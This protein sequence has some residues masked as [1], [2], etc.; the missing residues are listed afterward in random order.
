MFKY[1]VFLSAIVAVIYAVQEQQ[2]ARRPKFL[3]VVS[4]V[5]FP[6]SPCNGFNSTTGTCLSKLSCSIFGGNNSGISCAGGYGVCCNFFLSCG[7]VI[8][9]NNSYFVNPGYPDDYVNEGRCSLNVEKI[10]SNIEQIRLN[11][12]EFSINGVTNRACEQDVFQ[13]TGYNVNSLVPIFCGRNAGQ[14][15]Y[16][17]V[18]SVRGPL[19]LSM[20]TTSIGNRRWRIRVIQLERNNPS[21]TPRGCLQFFTGPSGN[22]RSFNYDAGVVSGQSNYLSNLN[23]ATCIRKES[24]YCGIQ[25]SAMTADEVSLAGPSEVSADTACAASPD[26]LYLGI[27]RYCGGSTANM[28]FTINSTVS[29]QIRAI[30]TTTGTLPSGTFRGYNLNYQQL[31][32]SDSP[33][34]G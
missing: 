32:C 14:H 12:E 13:V 29:G 4:W 24:G 6:N 27:S 25:Y 19:V 23:Y 31:V 5:I 20:L 16:I 18:K 8:S 28:P 22:F 26:A 17:D 3:P 10:N 34:S 15:V 1:L 9:R 11:F 7:S 2:T 33:S 30:F 21:K